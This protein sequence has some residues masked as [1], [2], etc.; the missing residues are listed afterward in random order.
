MKA[1]HYFFRI[2]LLIAYIISIIF[3]LSA[4]AWSASVA[5]V[6]LAYSGDFSSSNC[7]YD[8]NFN[9]VCDNTGDNPWKRYGASLAACAGIGA[10]IWILCIVHLVM[11]V[12]ACI[13]DPGT[14]APHNN[15]ELGQ[16]KAQEAY[17]QQQQTYPQQ[18]QP[19]HNGGAPYQQQQ[20]QYQQP[21]QQTY[22]TQ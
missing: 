13:R 3:W 17:P 4:W 20:P 7:H 10:L 5:S 1:Q 22:P 11:F 14:A 9:L 15:A 21:H 8:N 2:I 6:W 19:V 12:L 16:V 18:A